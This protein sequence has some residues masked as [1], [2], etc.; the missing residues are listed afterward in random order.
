MKTTFVLI[1]LIAILFTGN[2][3][4][5]ELPSNIASPKV[6][7][8][9]LPIISLTAPFLENGIKRPAYLELISENVSDSIGPY[10]VS[11]EISGNT[12]IRYPK[13]RLSFQ[14]TKKED[15]TKSI[16]RSLLNMRSDDDWVLDAAFR[17]N[18]LFR[19]RLNHNL[20][21]QITQSNQ[22]INSRMVEVYLNNVFYG[23]FT[24][25]EKID[26]K[27]LNMKKHSI[28]STF[29]TS[30]VKYF[31]NLSMKSKFEYF[32]R[33][34]R[35]IS[36]I[37]LKLE[38]LFPNTSELDEV[39]YKAS[40][41]G[42]NLSS[43]RGFSQKYPHSKYGISTSNLDNFVHFITTSSD[44]KFTQEI[45]EHVDRKSTI[46]YLCFL[47]LNTGQDNM[48]ANYYLLF[49]NG[50]FKFIPW[51][52]D[53]TFRSINIR[54]GQI[55]AKFNIWNFNSNALFKR[56]LSGT[57]KFFLN[58]LIIRWEQLRQDEFSNSSLK[59]L[60]MSE[61]E[62]LTKSQSIYRDHDLWNKPNPDAEFR[63][64]LEWLD[65]RLAF[66]DQ[67]LKKVRADQLGK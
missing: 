47:M 46:D 52:L 20:Y 17:D 43:L 26:H 12:S 11:I 30:F 60:F 58:D 32:H 3:F 57:D 10:P 54:N 40:T 1:L 35:A 22:T 36:R 42:S 33:I 41:F 65:Q 4:Q 64:V 23:V 19:N 59:A 25:S 28:Y 24:L 18:L 56:L 39:L 2:L 6:T 55:Q 66:V 8:T 29:K 34:N 7:P 49:Q 13:H 16:S 15:W 48:N 45:W 31:E 38:K 21:N 9:H 50:R 61:Y 5:Y 14:F 53:N 37:P 51:D 63:L 62:S 67:K 44:A 27:K